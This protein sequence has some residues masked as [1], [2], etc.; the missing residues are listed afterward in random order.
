[1]PDNKVVHSVSTRKD[2]FR[3]GGFRSEPALRCYFPW[4]LCPPARCRICLSFLAVGRCR[5]RH[6]SAGL[7]RS[8]S[9]SSRTI[10]SPS[11][12]LISSTWTPK[13]CKRWPCG[14]LFRG[15][16]P[17]FYL[18]SGS[19]LQATGPLLMSNN[20]ATFNT[21]ELCKAASAAFDPSFT[22]KKRS[23]PLM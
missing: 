11:I 2:G 15:F 12:R 14:L 8:Y 10:S 22:T 1:M 4:G 18:L 7:V 19:A 21:R 16:G 23:R 17:L 5:P 3:Q 20:A 6:H 9:R 13:V